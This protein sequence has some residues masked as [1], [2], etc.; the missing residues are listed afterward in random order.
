ML[1]GAPK[2][3]AAD[4]PLP[5]IAH[6]KEGSAELFHRVTERRADWPVQNADQ[7]VRLHSLVHDEL[8]E[9]LARARVEAAGRG[10]G[11]HVHERNVAPD[12]RRHVPRP[13][14]GFD[15]VG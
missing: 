4:P 7:R 9:A 14:S 13:L 5:T 10:L 8:L 3:R 1:R 6:E 15:R 2:P 12:R 11:S